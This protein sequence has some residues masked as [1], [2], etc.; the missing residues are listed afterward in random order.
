MQFK[1]VWQKIFLFWYACIQ[2]KALK[3]VTEPNTYH[4]DVVDTQGAIIMSGG[5]IAFFVSGKW[6][7]YLGETGAEH[8]R[9]PE[10]TDHWTLVPQKRQNFRGVD[11]VLGSFVGEQVFWSCQVDDGGDK[12]PIVTAYKNFNSSAILF[13]VQWPAGASNTTV[14]GSYKSALA[15]YPSFQV[16]LPDALSWR[17]SFIQSVRGMSEGTQGGPTVFYNGSDPALETVVVGSPWNFVWK[18]FSAG[19]N[20]S[21]RGGKSS[22]W[23]PGTSGRIARLP[24]GYRQSILLYQRPNGKGGITGTIDAWGQAMQKNGRGFPKLPDLTLEKIGYQTDNGAMYCFCKD[25]NCSQT[26]L[27]EIEYLRS[28]EVS[29]GYLSFQGAGASSGRGKAAPWCVDTWGVDGGL[30]PKVY[31]MDLLSFQKALGLPI[32]LYAPYFCP[33]SPYFDS[34]SIWESTPSDTNLPDCNDFAFVNV[35]PSQSRA[36]Y[37]WFMAKGVKAG[38]TS[39]E[40]DFMNQNYM[41]VPEFLKD[42][43]SAQDWQQGMAGA[44]L[45]KN[46]TIQWCYAA[47]TDVL[48]S[49]D[50]PAVTNFRVSFDFCYGRSWNIGES[51]LLVW[52]LGVAPSK[53]TLWSGPNNHTAVP[54]CPWTADHEESAA[55][56]HVVLALMS[57]GPVGLS[58]AIGYTNATLLKRIIMKDGSLLKPAKPLTAVDSTFLDTTQPILASNSVE[59]GGYVYG[60]SGVGSSWSFVSFLLP[61]AYEVKVRDFWP[62]PVGNNDNNKRLLFAYRSYGDGAGCQGGKDA[63]SSG[64]VV[65]TTAEND[66]SAGVFDAPM[67]TSDT[68]TAGQRSYAPTVTTVWRPC[69]ESQWIVLG[70]LNKYVPLSPKR[71]RSVECTKTGVSVNVRGSPGEEIELTALRPE[72]RTMHS[73]PAAES[74]IRYIVVKRTVYVPEHRNAMCHFQYPQ[75]TPKTSIGLAGELAQEQF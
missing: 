23:T 3:V 27:Q 42:V 57:N 36:F 24:K 15:N 71:F 31:P 74:E 38:M 63:L 13:D 43:S 16:H 51:S 52:A 22:Y 18:S 1:H 33:G 54:G 66:V 69:E 64:C 10:E 26:L 70:E 14:V 48:A 29:M 41:C 32:Q 60:T 20:R 19:D 37:D 45:A 53:D 6:C 50:M 62:S 39:F 12:V 49:L 67:A 17:G 30:N 8:D 56:L 75:V 61:D 4:Y 11:T 47:P 58:D 34:Q 25:S 68:A 59:K 44:A 28:Q 46:V 55:E 5:D 21:W 65:F 40:S 72:T 2:T 9:P 35:K 7:V 73:A